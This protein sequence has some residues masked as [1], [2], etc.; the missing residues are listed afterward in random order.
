MIGQGKKV[1]TSILVTLMASMMA[2]P[3]SLHPMA[4]K[5]FKQVS[6]LVNRLGIS[7]IPL[8]LILGEEIPLMSSVTGTP[9]GPKLPSGKAV[10]T[11][12]FGAL[13]S[14]TPGEPSSL[15][16]A[17]IP[18]LS[19]L[20]PEK[21]ETEPTAP[22]QQEPV[23][24]QPFNLSG[25]PLVAIYNTHTGESYELTEGAPRLEGKKGGVVKVAAALHKALEE[26]HGIRIVRS[27]TIHDKVFSR[28]YSQSEITARKL[29]EEN[30]SLNMIVDLH[31]D[32]ARERNVVKINGKDV[33]TVILVVGSNANLE[34][35][36]W[37]ENYAF[38]QKIVETTKAMYPGLAR[39]SGIMVKSGRYNQHL[40]PRAVLIEIGSNKNSTEEA[41]RSARLMADVLAEVIKANPLK[42]G[43][44]PSTQNQE[45]EQLTGDEPVD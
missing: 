37:K 30:R 3:L 9:A 14:V 42:A 44:P 21:Q 19:A 36:N 41:E 11:T 2:L 5:P 28:S 1:W 16:Q 6:K 4:S 7:N 10:A 15:L 31:R 8:E 27:D 26:K 45:K 17:A 20:K 40:H 34:H 39:G 13:T 25:E 38:A 35:P 12:A 18:R 22:I 33:A 43:I 23:D 24:Q 29:I 32:E